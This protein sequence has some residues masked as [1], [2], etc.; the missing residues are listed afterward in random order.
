MKIIDDCPANGYV[1]IW[2]INDYAEM[3][4]GTYWARVESKQE[5]LE[6]INNQNKGWGEKFELLHFSHYSH[7]VSIEPVNVVTEYKIK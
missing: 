1:L 5:G 7:K 3:G 2:C 6:I 4:G